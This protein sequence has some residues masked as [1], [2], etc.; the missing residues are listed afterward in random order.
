MRK[1]SFVIAVLSFSLALT[2]MRVVPYGVGDAVANFKLKN[3]DGKIVSLSDYKSSK[4]VIVVFDCNT[5]P[6]SK[7]YNTRIL[8]LSKKYGSKGFPL[9]AIN[10]NDPDVSPGDSFEDMVSEAKRKNYDFPYLVDETQDIARTFGATN[11][12]HVFVL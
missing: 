4:G 8:D 1:V 3:V 7:A 9:V 5:C 2:S 11:T 6:V 12:P 10:A